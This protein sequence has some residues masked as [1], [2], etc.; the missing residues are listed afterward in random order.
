MATDREHERRGAER[1]RASAVAW[2]ACP[3]AAASH[4]AASCWR[5]WHR[6]PWSCGCSA[7]ARAA[8]RARPTRERRGAVL[9]VARGAAPSDRGG[10]PGGSLA[11]RDG[12]DRRG[13]GPGVRVDHVPGTAGPVAFHDGA[14]RHPRAARVLRARGSTGRTPAEGT[15][16]DQ[17]AP[18]ARGDHGLRRDAPGGAHGRADRRASPR[19]RSPD[20]AGRADRLEG[21]RHAR[22]RGA[23]RDAWPFLR[24]AMRPGRRHD[25]RRSTGSLP[26]D[27]AATLTTIGTGGLPSPH[28]I[29][30]TLVRDDDGAVARAWSAPA[31]PAR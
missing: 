1:R 7:S 8:T 9:P 10:V 2:S 6:L 27:P 23:T 3:S 29:T 25:S 13:T 4:A 15:G 24:R 28:G 16:L 11:R 14:S 19:R 20:A 22:P 18:D 31:H 17:I 30:G 26:L 21:R 12:R 5:S